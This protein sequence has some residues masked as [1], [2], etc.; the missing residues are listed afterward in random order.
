MGPVGVLALQGGVAEHE[1]MLGELGVETVRVRTP[2]QLDQVAALVL[3]GG[4]STTLI[5]LMEKWGLVEPLRSKGQSG[6]PILGTCAGA[7]LLSTRVSEAEHS[8]VQESLGLADVQA[9]RNRFGRQTRSFLTEL[10]IKGLDGPYPGL[11]IRAPLLHP[12]SDEVEVLSSVQEGA[13]LLRQGNIWLSSFHPELTSD[14]RI[15]QM[16]LRSSGLLHTED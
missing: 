8:V 6:L 4:E 15:H 11:F 10:I 16:F 5:S 12:L 1:R 2:E 14:N 9:I 13:V 3:P 7:V